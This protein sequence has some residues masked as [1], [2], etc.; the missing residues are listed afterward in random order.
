MRFYNLIFSGL[1]GFL[2]LNAL[3]TEE[4]LQRT[5][6][7]VVVSNLSSKVVLK[8]V[9]IDQP[10]VSAFLL[11]NLNAQKKRGDNNYAQSIL[12]RLINADPGKTLEWLLNKY[13]TMTGSG[14]KEMLNS[15]RHPDVK[16][17]YEIV[18]LLIRNKEEVVSDHAAALAPGP[19]KHKRICD[20]AYTALTWMIQND[21]PLPEGLPAYILPSDSLEER[22]KR[23]SRLLSWWSKESAKVLE[24]KKSLSTDRPALKEKMQ[25]F[26]EKNWNIPSV[27]AET[28]EPNSKVPKSK[29][30]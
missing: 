4:E 24:K 6:Q 5:F 13:T 22:D 27:K 12:Y 3:A 16:E 9:D 26:R 8:E 1:L 18:S 20:F 23:I 2:S 11:K 30:K 7:K 28:E 17:A 25:L 15:L 19:Y 29:S 10:D 21:I 14:R